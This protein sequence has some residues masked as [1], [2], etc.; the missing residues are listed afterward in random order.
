M[1]AFNFVRTSLVACAGASLLL[2]VDHSSACTW[3]TPG[4]QGDNFA[5]WDAS[6]WKCSQPFIDY[7]WSAYDFDVGDWDA[8]WGYSAPCDNAKP[9]ARTF[10]SLYS[11]GYS[12]TGTPSCNTSQSNMS[13]W[14]MCWSASWIDELDGG[15]TTSSGAAAD[16][17]NDPFAAD[18]YTTLYKPFFYGAMTSTRGGAI[19]HE[20]RH[21]QENCDHN[22][23]TTCK[24]GSSCD[25]SWGNGCGGDARQG[26]NTY[27][28]VYLSWYLSTAWRTTQALKDAAFL[29][30]NDVLG[31]G[32]TFDPCFRLSS[33]GSA[34]SVC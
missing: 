11:L 21:A 32:Y 28:V 20:A 30:A 12:S 9:L 17:V 1:D 2:L 8:E 18:H 33:N 29:Q 14:A 13:L 7:W 19:A 15:C 24:R 26:S 27:E 10:N 5:M 6:G 22:G 25:F 16:T 23:G 34:Y 4:D 3:P 31:R